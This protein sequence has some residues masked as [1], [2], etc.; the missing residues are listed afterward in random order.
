MFKINGQPI[1]YILDK[2]NKNVPV[3]VYQ[4][5]FSNLQKPVC[6]NAIKL[7]HNT[8]VRNIKIKVNMFNQII[9]YKLVFYQHLEVTKLY[10][11]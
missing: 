3:A 8:N 6:H 7:H 10:K 2:C 4:L 11:A 5:D 9:I 1:T